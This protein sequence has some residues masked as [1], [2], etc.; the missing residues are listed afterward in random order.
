MKRSLIGP[1]SYADALTKRT[2][3]Q[4]R[5]HEINRRT[6]MKRGS[7]M[8]RTT[9]H[10]GPGRRM[11][12]WSKIW[13][14]LKPELE[15]RGRTKCEFHFIK[16]ECWGALYPCHSKKRREMEGDDIYAVAMGCQQVARLLDEA[17]THKEMEAAVMRAINENGGVIL[18]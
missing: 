17:L 1:K 13:R 7:R 5:K 8:K 10:I 4:Q 6:P 9:K 12:S 14:W 2:A 3:L 16:H 11:K 18:K 15:K